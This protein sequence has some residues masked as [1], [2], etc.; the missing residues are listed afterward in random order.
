MATVAQDTVLTPALTPRLIDPRGVLYGRRCRNAAL[1]Y[2]ERGWPVLPLHTADGGRCSCGQAGCRRP[3]RHPRPPTGVRE[4]TA[5]A[6]VIR[7]WWR[8]W[9]DTGVG[10]ATGAVSGL[11]GVA[12]D[13][14]RRGLSE[15]QRLQGPDGVGPDT[16]ALAD[17]PG[18]CLKL[19]AHPR[20]DR[21]LQSLPAVGGCLGIAVIG[22]GGWVPAPPSRSP[23]GSRVQWLPPCDPAVEAPE[24]LPAWLLQLLGPASGRLEEYSLAQLQALD[25]PDPR[26]PIR[27]LLAEG[28]TILAGPPKVGKSWLLLEWGLAITM[29]QPA[30]GLLD[31]DPGE[32][33]YAAMEDTARRLK[34]R[35]DRLLGPDR[36]WPGCLEVTHRLP[37]SNAGLV[38]TLAA[39]LKAHPNARLVMLDTLA[40]ISPRWR[41]RDWYAD[42]YALGEKLQQLAA[43]HHVALV[44]STHLTKRLT[45]DPV[46]QVRGSIGVTGS[47]DTILVLRRVRGQE[48]GS[49]LITG[50]D[51]EEQELVVTFEHGHWT[52]GGPAAPFQLSAERAA[53][54]QALRHAPGPQTPRQLADR[55]GKTHG[56]SGSCSGRW[57]KT[58]RC[59]GS[60][61]GAAGRPTRSRTSRRRGGWPA[62]AP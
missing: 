21:L 24:P 20:Q 35:M 56:R 54:L 59:R 57:R 8:R 51:V 14:A 22:D 58:G 46:E 23:G 41:S 19:F 44:V 5:D 18:R 31:V 29:G 43:D 30:F 48:E 1:T 6:A 13:E 4:A 15:W 40:K 3:G 2:A 42:D 37:R 28:L 49:L 25:L 60:G 17:G 9:P 45:A 38:D 10:V 62:P 52:L 36:P 11:M 55:L 53:V 61:P 12:L 39:W 34:A 7:R 26:W 47:A 33:L 16:L 32:V 27:D 50:R